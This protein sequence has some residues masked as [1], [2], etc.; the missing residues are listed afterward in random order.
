[1][2]H[3][4]DPQQCRSAKPCG[5]GKARVGTIRGSQDPPEPLKRQSQLQLTEWS[6][7]HTGIPRSGEGPDHPS[8]ARTHGGAYRSRAE[9]SR[10]GGSHASDGGPNLEGFQPHQSQVGTT[11]GGA[12]QRQGPQGPTRQQQEGDQ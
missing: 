7:G 9:G 5:Q 2:L 4:T 12:P 11:K 6:P 3:T 8:V 1:M 10:L